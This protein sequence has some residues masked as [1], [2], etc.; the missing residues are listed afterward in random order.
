MWGARENESLRFWSE[1]LEGSIWK[2]LLTDGGKSAGEADVRHGVLY[3]ELSL[4][5]IKFEMLI[6]YLS[7]DVK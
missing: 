4:E 2:L 1:Q 6:R 5:H 7:G 3:Q